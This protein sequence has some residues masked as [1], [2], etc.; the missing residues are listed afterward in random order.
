MHRRTL[1]I[2][3]NEVQPVSPA[4]YAG[5]LARW[6]HLHP[7]TRLAG[8]GGLRRLL[9]N[10][11]PAPVAGPHLGTRPAAA[12]PDSLRTAGTGR[13]LPE[14]RIGLGR[15]RRRGRPAAAH[16]LS[17]PRRRR[18][19]SWQRRPDDLTAVLGRQMRRPSTPSCAAKAPSL[20]PTC[21]RRWTW[22]RRRWTAAALWELAAAGLATNDSLAAL[23]EPAAAWRDSRLPNANRSARWRPSLAE[24]LAQQQQRAKRSL[25]Q[26]NEAAFRLP[27]PTPGAELAAARRRRPSVQPAR[28]GRTERTASPRDGRWTLVHRFGVLGKPLPPSSEGLAARQA[29]QLLAPPRRRHP[30]Q[31]RRRNRGLRLGLRSTPNCNALEGGDVRRELLC[32]WPA[33]RAVCAARSGGRWR[34]AA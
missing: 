28:P 17:L 6:Q 11:A 33:R 32:G 9:G 15:L 22:P 25:R 18:S 4:A 21:A 30:C 16:P 3:R 8:E 13:P 2:L 31:P 29:R 34:R 26:H 19:L 24:R 5:F 14:R 20:P 23:R 12:A 10:C 1:T 27:G 7:A